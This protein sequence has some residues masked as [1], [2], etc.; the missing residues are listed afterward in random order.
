MVWCGKRTESIVL[1]LQVL[2]NFTLFFFWDRISSISG[3]F[4]TLYVAKD[5]SEL[6]TLLP[7]ISWV[8]GCMPHGRFVH[9]WGLNPDIMNVRQS[10]YQLSYIPSPRFLVTL[11]STLPLN[12][13]TSYACVNSSEGTLVA[14]ALEGK[15]IFIMTLTRILIEKWKGLRDIDIAVLSLV[16]S[17]YDLGMRKWLS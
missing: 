7:L 17:P 3:W 12:G 13:C 16:F 4:W 14:T 2:I 6:L 10:L 1:D 8:L 9:Y 15:L 5:D 11:G